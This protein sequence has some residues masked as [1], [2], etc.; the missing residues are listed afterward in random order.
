MHFCNICITVFGTVTYLAPQLTRSVSSLTIFAFSSPTAK[1]PKQLCIPPVP[2]YLFAV[3]TLLFVVLV[4]CSPCSGFP[5]YQLL[6]L[7]FQFR[8]PLLFTLFGVFF[9]KRFV[10]LYEGCKRE[11]IQE[12]RTSIHVSHLGA[13]GPST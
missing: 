9:L 6:C 8:L 7:A 5:T 10:Y 13:G 1:Q 2:H 4:V 11:K 3:I 12:V